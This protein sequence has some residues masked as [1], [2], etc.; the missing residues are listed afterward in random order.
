MK[1]TAGFNPK[2][3]DSTETRSIPDA[4]PP[5]PGFIGADGQP[6]F[7]QPKTAFGSVGTRAKSHSM[8][9]LDP[10][11]NADFN[12]LGV[13]LTSGAGWLAHSAN[14]RAAE[15]MD[16]KLVEVGGEYYSRTDGRRI[17]IDEAVA[18]DLP[19]LIPQELRS[20]LE[21]RQFN[22]DML[23]QSESFEDGVSFLK[24]FLLKTRLDDSLVA[25]ANGWIESTL[26]FTANL[27]LDVITDPLN[28]VTLGGGAGLRLGA[29][30]VAKKVAKN[31]LSKTA[32][33]ITPV[34]RFILSA[35]T[36]LEKNATIT[37][38]VIDSPWTRSHASIM[39]MADASAFAAVFDTLYQREAG[40]LVNTYLDPD[41]PWWDPTQT[42]A[43]VFIGAGAAFGL[44]KLLVEPTL[45]RR[46]MDT[47]Y[48]LSPT[49]KAPEG[50]VGPGEPARQNVEA[51]KL[52]S[53]LFTPEGKVAPRVSN[54]I[55][56]ESR[57][58]FDDALDILNPD[59]VTDDMVDSITLNYLNTFSAAQRHDIKPFI[60]TGSYDKISLAKFLVQ[61]PT[62]KEV[63]DF[64]GI[65]DESRV[66]KLT[67][68]LVV[69]RAERVRLIKSA[70]V[71]R[72]NPDALEALDKQTRELKELR[73]QLK[74]TRA[75]AKIV[76]LKKKIVKKQEEIK[77]SESTMLVDKSARRGRLN[78]QVR[79]LLKK[80]EDAAEAE[81]QRTLYPVAPTN[82]RLRKLAQDIAPL[83]L[84]YVQLMRE[85]YDLN[86]ERINQISEILDG[87]D[88]ELIAIGRSITGG[89]RR[90]ATEG[91]ISF[92]IQL[93]DVIIPSIAR[94]RTMSAAEQANVMSHLF[95]TNQATFKLYNDTAAARLFNMKALS[96]FASIGIRRWD[97]EQAVIRSPIA[98]VVA[99]MIHPLAQS[100]SSLVPGK[101]TIRSSSSLYRAN[102]A[103][104]QKTLQ[105]PFNNIEKKLRG[106]ERELT[107]R[108]SMQV[109]GGVKGGDTKLVKDMAK[110]YREFYDSHGDYGLRTGVLDRVLKDYV[111]I[112][113]NPEAARRHQEQLGKWLYERY[114]KT[115]NTKRKSAVHRGTLIRTGALT[116]KPDGSWRWA[117]GLEDLKTLPKTVS[118]LDSI[119]LPDGLNLGDLYRDRLASVLQGQA[120]DAL[121]NKINPS[122][123]KK[124]S[125]EAIARGDTPQAR[126]TPLT[127]M[128]QKIEQ[129]F[130]L[131]DR[132]LDLGVV[133]MNPISGALNYTFGTAN[134]FARQDAVNQITGRQ[135][136]Q[137]EGL[138]EMVRLDILQRSGKTQAD[139]LMADSIIKVL[140]DADGDISGRNLLNVEGDSAM[141]IIATNLKNMGSVFV[142]AGIAVAMASVEV[143]SSILQA[144]LQNSGKN[145]AKSL[146]RIVG[147]RELEKEMLKSM[148][149]A[150]D[151]V[152]RENRVLAG[153]GFVD[154]AIVASW[155]RRLW[156][157]IKQ[158]GETATGKKTAIRSLRGGGGG[159][160]VTTL[161][162]ITEAASDITRMGSGEE[163]MTN[164]SRAVL[165]HSYR[166]SVYEYMPKIKA[167]STLKTDGTLAGL[168]TAAREAKFG[169][170]W[171]V[172]QQF[173]DA[174]FTSKEFLDAF[175]VLVNMGV[176]DFGDPREVAKALSRIEDR[177]LRFAISKQMDLI[178]DF[179][180]KRVDSLI[181]NPSVWD[182][183]PHLQNPLIQLLNSFLSYPRGFRSNRLRSLADRG[184]G[185][186]AFW[187]SAYLSFELLN[188]Q[189]QLMVFGGVTP[190]QLAEKWEDDPYSMLRRGLL[191]VPF[192]GPYQAQLQSI[193]E[194]L[195]G[196]QQRISFDA[197]AT[198][199]AAQ[200][201]SDALSVVRAGISSEVDLDPK[202]MRRL[203]RAMPILNW[204]PVQILRAAL[205][206]SDL[207]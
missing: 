178:D 173:M 158:I 125:D 17:S 150:L 97:A 40:E 118:E 121:A 168:K 8:L 207:D 11:E 117:N 185:S 187:S 81:L 141:Q 91:Q 64:L 58:V 154:D 201:L 56:P 94:K 93:Q 3:F 153:A 48:L 204:T 106:K 157:P 181:I 87:A 83:R 32:A 164:L 78:P 38:A 182:R 101:E 13:A 155:S 172:A 27:G 126:R 55:S 65:V 37:G 31:Q 206:P 148:G 127:D 133:D 76:T 128:E 88:A 183:A 199:I 184:F 194:G 191:G 75:K 186:L 137:W 105:T 95:L 10:T 163:I 57:Q 16:L 119:T 1:P 198:G 112:N 165:G 143:P 84:E 6:S 116:S 134:R 29:N 152:V 115:F 28:I 145:S 9:L 156:A 193:L 34:D 135:D 35:T 138:M 71:N 203:E 52:I 12:A 42:A 109:A 61:K 77:Q 130:F 14:K 171:V 80:A 107:Y 124:L 99:N 96:W 22:F 162:A 175:D 72:T 73:A 50:A 69:I 62:L 21:F 202:A 177:D 147:S 114:S 24:Y 47:A 4:V 110:A 102:S 151:F 66:D 44:S 136:I 129:D 49:G 36:R 30:S 179:A 54:T 159:R 39:A 98:N 51:A 169:K 161:T 190:E 200:L 149:R 146:A 2:P 41:A 196:N 5:Q 86:T 111:H 174:G 197:P 100:N 170:R 33:N 70:Q 90:E 20:L 180:V 68:D 132:V 89:E 46:E 122:Y 45:R 43:S 92:Q 23:A 7:R 25:N 82:T 15:N 144:T 123:G 104:V 113:L 188:R 85:G 18:A 192:V 205:T 103:H 167:L 59:N 142:N 19:D 79:A 131:Q 189:M 108:N 53:E 139:Q 26:G 166:S 74:A 176:T 63:K 195:A 67:N 160:A 140:Q 120:D 60:D